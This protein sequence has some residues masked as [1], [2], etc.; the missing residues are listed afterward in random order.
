MTEIP[1]PPPP[2]N[3]QVPA[4]LKLPLDIGRTLARYY[5]DFGWLISM[6]GKKVPKEL[7][8]ALRRLARGENN[9]V[10]DLNE[11]AAG[12]NQQQR[13][14]VQAGEIP[15]PRIG[16]RV[17]TTDDALVAW[18]MHY[19]QGLGYRDIAK[20]FTEELGCPVSHSTVSNYIAE[21]DEE[22]EED[23]STRTGKILKGVVIPA[24]CIILTF[25]IS[26][27]LVH[28]P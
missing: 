28:W 25:L 14:D 18:R 20:Y 1:P 26:K 27:F 24:V 22:M 2:D 7:D 23:R 13:Y 10:E 5:V 15:E 21:L 8:I 6:T 17:F 16:E 19:K 4:F 12:Q 11:M 3:A 9:A